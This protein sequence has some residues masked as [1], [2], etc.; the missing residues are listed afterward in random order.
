MAFKK[1]EHGVQQFEI[2][3]MRERVRK[4]ENPSPAIRPGLQ[5]IEPRQALVIWVLLLL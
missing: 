1:N 5:Q 2:D 4:L 3:E